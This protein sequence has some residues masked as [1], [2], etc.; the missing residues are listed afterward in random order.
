MINYETNDQSVSPVVAYHVA[1][2]NIGNVEL[3][4]PQDEIVSIESTFTLNSMQEIKLSI[5]EISRDNVKVP[6]YCFSESMEILTGRPDDISKCVVIRHP[7]GDFSIVCNEIQNL[8]L[9]DMRLQNVP[10][11]M[12][13]HHVPLT[14]LCLYKETDNVMKLGLVSNADCLHEYINDV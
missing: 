13:S 9:S 4:I 3:I 7:D 12:N 11:C 6:V 10:A 2:L 1:R 5:G 14:Y 8:V